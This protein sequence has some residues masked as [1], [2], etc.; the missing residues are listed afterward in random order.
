MNSEIY[1]KR[2]RLEKSLLNN[3]SVFSINHLMPSIEKLLLEKGK[4]MVCYLAH[5]YTKEK[6]TEVKITFPCQSRS[7]IYN[8]SIEIIKVKNYRL[9]FCVGRSHT[10]SSI[11]I[12]LSEPTGDNRA[13]NRERIPLIELSNQIKAQCCHIWS[14][15]KRNSSLS[16]TNISFKRNKWIV[17]YQRCNRSRFF[18]TGPPPGQTQSDR[19]VPTGRPAWVIKGFSH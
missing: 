8:F 11:D 5:I 17:P 14:V 3:S 15:N 6:S 2:T 7:C 10:N 4:V 9:L 18:V 1:K 19:T 16:I 13:P 12:F